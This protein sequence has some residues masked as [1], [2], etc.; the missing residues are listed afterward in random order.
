MEEHLRFSKIIALLSLGFFVFLYLFLNSASEFYFALTNP[1]ASLHYHYD[2][3]LE[4]VRIYDI[5]GRPSQSVSGIKSGDLVLSVNGELVTN[6]WRFA[7]A[8]IS[9]DPGEQAK[10]RVLRSQKPVTIFYDPA[11]PVDQMNLFLSLLPTVVFSY[12]LCLIATFVLIKRIHAPEARL[13]YLML[14]F[15]ALAIRET[16]PNGYFLHNLMPSWFREVALTPAWPLAIGT[17]L[18]FFLRFPQENRLMVSHRRH[19]LAS[20]YAPLILLLPYFYGLC[21]KLHW[22]G[23]LLR[24][25]WGFWLSINFLIALYVMAGVYRKSSNAHV[26]KQAEL[27]L[28]GTVISLGLPFVAY[29][30]PR[31]LLGRPLPYGEFTTP[32]IVLWPFW[33]AYAIIKHRFMNIDFLVKR[34]VA[35]ALASGFVVAAYFVLVVGVGKLVLQLSGATSQLMT[36]LATLAIAAVFNPVKN[37]IQSFVERRFYPSRFTYRR[38]IQDFGHQ[39]VNILDPEK[40]LARLRTFLVQQINLR[41]VTI[42]WRRDNGGIYQARFSD[43]LSLSDL[44]SFDASDLVVKRLKTKARLVDLSPLR[45]DSELMSESERMKWDQIQTEMVMPLLTKG[46]LAGFLSLGPKSGDEPYFNQDLELLQSLCDRVNMALENAVLTEQLRQQD[47]LKRELEVARRIQLSSLPQSEP[48]VSGLEVSS[49]SVPALEVGG[50][51]YDY[52]SFPNDTFGVV[53]ADVSGKGTSAALYM[54]QLKGIVNTAAQ[55]H[56]S[57]KEMVVEVNSIVCRNMESKSFITLTCAA[58]DVNR[59][60][61]HLVRAGHLPALFY[62]VAARRCCEL[63]PSGIGLGMEAGHVFLANTEELEVAINPG[64]L[65][66]LYSDGI[67]EARN[68]YDQ[69]FGCDTL[70]KIVQNSCK[71]S[72]TA[73]RDVILSEV[74][75]FK[76]GLPQIDDIT[77]VVVKI[78]K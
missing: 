77:L 32:I 19:V 74:E 70:V 15:W 44:P 28:F 40:L 38:A 67:T 72:A 1:A 36:I 71:L 52:L 60:K 61:M 78:T 25:G 9:L 31:L 17:L 26:K 4:G 20:V 16:F 34:G 76:Q 66:V 3:E 8:L 11:S 10:I 21:S 73:L 24:Y 29:F 42:F 41:P 58:F 69:E 54:S 75:R 7:R 57:L 18:H 12:S 53:V 35:Y 51:Y 49:I 6:E 64:D 37:R 45:N 2:E 50:D 65:I 59:G 62:S 23:S 30:L 56:Q 27:M 48:R 13:F 47:R 43:G 39:L 5:G 68:H 63:E 14:I 46:E 33:L 55:Y 22:T